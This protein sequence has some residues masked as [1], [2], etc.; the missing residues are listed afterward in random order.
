MKWLVIFLSVMTVCA[1][2]QP[3]PDRGPPQF[4]SLPDGRFRFAGPV[5]ERVEANVQ[6]WLLE[7]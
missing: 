3:L 5:G 1:I 2:A 4:Q 6:N 7:L